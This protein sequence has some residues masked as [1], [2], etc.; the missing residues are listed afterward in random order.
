MKTIALVLALNAA[1][2]ASTAAFAEENLQP[3]PQN[4]Q[5]APVQ[6]PV[7]QSA[8]ANEQAAP[9]AQGAHYL[10]NLCTNGNP[11]IEYRDCINAAT[12]DAN[13]KVRDV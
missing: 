2:F 5:A 13:A 12:R 8:T 6:A 1:L 7:S 10:N 9:P 3:Q 4:E 11:F